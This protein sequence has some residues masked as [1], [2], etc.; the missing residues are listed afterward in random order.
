MKCPSCSAPVDPTVSVCPHCGHQFDQQGTAKR[1]MMG[2]PSMQRDEPDN[3]EPTQ[4]RPRSTLFGIP[5]ATGNRPPQGEPEGLSESTSP[6]QVDEQTLQE[7]D[8][9]TRVV[10]DLDLDGVLDEMPAFDEPSGGQRSSHATEF[11]LPALDS[12]E[13]GQ[14]APAKAAPQ[15]SFASAWGLDEESS[16]PESSS[17]QVAGASL[18]QAILESKQGATGFSKSTAPS[19]APVH[20]TLMGMS[21]GE[22][23]PAEDSTQEVRRSRLEALSKAAAAQSAAEQEEP[24]PPFEQDDDATQALDP[25]ALA[26]FEERIQSDRRKQLLQK[27][28]GDKTSGA[29]DAATPTPTPVPHADEV[30]RSTAKGIPAAPSQNDTPI[31]SSANA[32]S[33][34]ERERVPSGPRFSIPS[35]SSKPAEPE[36]PQELTVEP[37]EPLDA[38]DEPEPRPSFGGGQTSF[39]VGPSSAGQSAESAEPDLEIPVVPVEPEVAVDESVSTDGD[40]AFALGDTG[41]L[42]GDDA[43]VE[44]APAAAGQG[45]GEIRA[46][47]D[48]DDGGEPIFPIDAQPTSQPAPVDLNQEVSP[49][50]PQRTSPNFGETPAPGTSVD[51]WANPQR[52]PTQQAQ[53]A[54]QAF[55][56]PQQRQPAQGVHSQQS[57]PPAPSPAAQPPQADDPTVKLVKTVRLLFGLLGVLFLIGAAVAGTVFAAMTAAIFLGVGG[58]LLLACA[59][60]FPLVLKLVK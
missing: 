16:E 31:P 44:P 45:M 24:E 46:F 27:L 56:A 10:S 18:A 55:Q 25:E 32:F 8:A 48:A 50:T 59:A 30:P 22:E 36:E 49:A 4:E 9:S 21:L 60:A 2:L 11:G 23:P 52:P 6:S 3:Q 17:T 14:G 51:Q 43:D 39:P 7:S 33:Q 35:P 1:T 19:D 58:V 42:S 37:L 53:Q 41:V 34:P 26:Q 57:Q 13:S 5:A 15:N 20:G 47:D 28:R 54:Q 12:G 40:M 38:L 29:D